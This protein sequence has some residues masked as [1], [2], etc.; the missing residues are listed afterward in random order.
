MKIPFLNPSK[1][2]SDT[3]IEMAM[4]LLRKL[5][6]EVATAEIEAELSR[7]ASNIRVLKPRNAGKKNN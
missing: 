2:L 1:R 4:E 5:R 6:L 7:V 3:E